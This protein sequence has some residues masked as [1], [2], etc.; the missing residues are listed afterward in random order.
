MDLSLT[1]PSGVNPA[2]ALPTAARQRVAPPP[3][4]TASVSGVAS[5]QSAPGNPG[6][7]WERV[8]YEEA[9]ALLLDPDLDY[10]LDLF[11]RP[12]HY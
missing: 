8:A 5:E 3:P 12:N 11:A 7:H 4:P 1:L 6:A 2:A 9:A 10:M